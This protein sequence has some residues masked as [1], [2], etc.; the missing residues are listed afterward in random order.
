[1]NSATP[2]AMTRFTPSEKRG[3]VF[4]QPTVIPVKPISQV[5]LSPESITN[6]ILQA[7]SACLEQDRTGRTIT[8]NDVEK[9]LADN[10]E[11]TVRATQ[12]SYI[13]SAGRKLSSDYLISGEDH[14]TVFPTVSE[15][16]Q[17]G[18][19]YRAT[20]DTNDL[21][22]WK[23]LLITGL[24][25][26]THIELTNIVYDSNNVPISCNLQITRTR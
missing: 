5:T 9:R 15:D 18:R 2:A 25:N 23:I 17:D 3:I 24:H 20:Y 19:S 10:G 26:D 11:E 21:N 16:L 4:S 8:Q 7:Q 22:P 14:V 13:T 6:L 12:G 1:M